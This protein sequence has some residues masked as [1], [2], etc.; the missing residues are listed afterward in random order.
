M[1]NFAFHIWMQNSCINICIYEF[2]KKITFA[3]PCF[4]QILTSRCFFYYF[5]Q[6]TKR[7]MAAKT[8]TRTLRGCCPC[9][10]LWSASSSSP[11]WS[12]CCS[13][14]TPA[15][16]KTR[17]VLILGSN[18]NS[19]SRNNFSLSRHNR[20]ERTLL[21]SRTS[22]GKFFLSHSISKRWTV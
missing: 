4:Y 3:H 5:C 20:S 7:K 22:L 17:Q 21:A 11:S 13:V 18:P 2:A 19:S 1:W 12:W 6:M 8:M 16:G 10:R 14:T 9:S 15:E